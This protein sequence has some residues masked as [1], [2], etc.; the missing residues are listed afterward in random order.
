MG[1]KTHIRR[2]R[3]KAVRVT[4]CRGLQEMLLGGLTRREGGPGSRLS[5]TVRIPPSFRRLRGALGS[6]PCLPPTF[7]WGL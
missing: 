4:H 5:E 3:S 7:K 6:W 1:A 2:Q